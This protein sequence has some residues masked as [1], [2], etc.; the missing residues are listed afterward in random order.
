[1]QTTR[2]GQISDEY[3]MSA[4]GKNVS[5]ILHEQFPRNVVGYTY[6]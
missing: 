3:A 6:P 4:C 5:Q 1:M 2:Q